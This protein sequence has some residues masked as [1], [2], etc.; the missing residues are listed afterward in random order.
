MSEISINVGCTPK[1]SSSTKAAWKDTF[2]TFM[3]ELRNLKA[4]DMSDLG[5]AL[6]KTFDLLNLYRLQ[7]GIDTF[8]MVH[9]VN[10]FV[11]EPSLNCFIL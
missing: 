3:T 9:A 4:H 7:T 6:R 10:C 2:A 1:I 11:R 5:G 8:G